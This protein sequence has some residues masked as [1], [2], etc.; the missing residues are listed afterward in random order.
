MKIIRYLYILKFFILYI[1]KDK[2]K[3]MGKKF[4]K[5]K[6]LLFSF[7]CSLHTSFFLFFFFFSNNWGTFHGQALRT[8]HGDPNLKV[9]TAP[10]QPI[11]SKFRVSSVARFKPKTMCHLLRPHFPVF[12]LTNWATL[13]CLLH[14]TFERDMCN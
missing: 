8:L 3:I 5:L 11:P 7:T 2:I 13:A 14:C 1:I 9:L 10:Q 12:T 4:I 6:Y